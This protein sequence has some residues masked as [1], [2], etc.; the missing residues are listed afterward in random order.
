MNPPK[1]VNFMAA[2][3]LE[4]PLE[5]N[6]FDFMMSF[7]TL[8]HIYPEDAPQ[9]AKEV[10][11]LLKPGGIFLLSIPYDKAY[12]DP[13]HVAFYNVETLTQLFEN[14]GLYTVEATK[15]N[16]WQEKDLLTALFTKLPP[17]QSLAPHEKLQESLKS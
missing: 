14:A 17:E 3:L 16:R 13:A 10:H 7:H 2:N 5:D 11:R 6:K 4:I 12:P 15:D 9:F 8:E 1:P